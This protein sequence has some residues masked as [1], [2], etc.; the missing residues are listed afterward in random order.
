LGIF[1]KMNKRQKKFLHLII[2]E[3]KA[4]RHKLIELWEKSGKWEVREK[5]LMFRKELYA[6][7]KAEH[8]EL[9]SKEIRL[10][11]RERW[12]GLSDCEKSKYM[13]VEEKKPR[14]KTA[15][16]NYFKQTYPLIKTE[17]KDWKLSETSKEISRRWKLLSDQEKTVYN[18]ENITDE[19]YDKIKSVFEEKVKTEKKVVTL[20]EEE[21]NLIG[22]KED[23]YLDENEK[24]EIREFLQLNFADKSIETLSKLLKDNYNEDVSKLTEK[25]KILDKLYQLEREEKIKTNLDNKRLLIPQELLDLSKKE[26]IYM[27]EK[28]TGLEK[29]EYWAVELQYRN[30]FADH[31]ISE[32][33]SKDE[34][35]QKIL[36]AEMENLV[37][38]KSFKIMGIRC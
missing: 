35:I 24:N 36:E 19:K 8:P 16:Q 33:W 31:D 38:E 4:N 29:M 34:M 15:Y 37:H 17:N 1:K 30:V 7:L 21:K 22:A 12:N 32:N 14:K 20:V 5:Y 27:E 13:V 11:I 25:E 10:I 3:C 9:D 2:I 26:K 23:L 18:P 28:K 6:G